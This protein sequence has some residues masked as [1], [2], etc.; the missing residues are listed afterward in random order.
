[1]RGQHIIDEPA[2]LPVEYAAVGDQVAQLSA[3]KV[4]APGRR[5]TADLLGDPPRDRVAGPHQH[6]GD[7]AE[8]A[9]GHAGTTTC[10][11]VATPG[12]AASTAPGPGTAIAH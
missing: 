7:R 9:D 6:P 2:L 4:L 12:S 3:G 1:P 10:G 5:A 11:L 8:Q